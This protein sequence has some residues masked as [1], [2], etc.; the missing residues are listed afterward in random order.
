[1]GSVKRLTKNGRGAPESDEESNSD[2]SIA[3]IK[4]LVAK[5]T[6]TNALEDANGRFDT[7]K[8]RS[9]GMEG[10][11][12]SADSSPKSLEHLFNVRVANRFGLLYDP[13][14]DMNIQS[15]PSP[16]ESPSP[17]ETLQNRPPSPEGAARREPRPPPIY[18]MARLGSEHT[19]FRRKIDGIPKNYYLQ[20]TAK[21][22]IFY[23]R[24][25]A[26]YK[27]FI[28]TFKDIL[29]FY[30]FTPRNEKTHAYMV[31]GLHSDA[32]PEE[33][34]EKLSGLNIC[35]QR[36]TR[37]GKPEY[38]MF[39]VI[40]DNKTSLKDITKK[41]RF[42][43]RTRIY[44][45]PHYNK[46]LITQCQADN[47][48]QPPRNTE[49]SRNRR[50]S[51]PPLTRSRLPR[52]EFPPL[53]APRQIRAQRP[54]PSQTAW[55]QSASP[56][57]NNDDLKNLRDI[58]AT[59]SE[60]NKIVNLRWLAERVRDLHEQIKQARPPT[61]MDLKIAQWNCDG[62]RTKMGELI[63]FLS[64]RNVDLVALSETKL[65][66]SWDLQLRGY[67][68]VRKDG[69][70][71]QGGVAIAIRNTIPF[72]RIALPEPNSLEA[73]AIR[74]A[75]S[76][77]VVSLYNSPRKRL[78]INQ[79]DTLFGLA[80]KVLIAATTPGTATPTTRTETCC[81]TTPSPTNVARLNDIDTD[82]LPSDHIPL[83]Y[84]LGNGRDLQRRGNKIRVHDYA[85]E[86]WK[87]FRECLNTD[88]TMVSDLDTTRKM[89]DIVDALTTK[90]ASAADRSALYRTIHLERSD[91]LP[92]EI[93]SLIRQRNALR[94]R[95][96]AT[97]NTN[98]KKEANRIT[99]RIRWIYLAANPQS[100]QIAPDYPAAGEI[101]RDS[102]CYP[103]GNIRRNASNFEAFHLTP[104]TSPQQ[105]DLV[106]RTV[107]SFLTN[108][109]VNLSES[110]RFLTNPSMKAPGPDTIQNIVLKNL[111]KKMIV[112]LTYVVAIIKLQHY[113]QQWKTA[114]VI[115]VP[116]PNKD[117]SQSSSYRP[118][119]LLSTLSKVAE[120]II[121]GHINE[122]LERNSIIPPYQFGFRSEHNTN[123]Q[124]ARLVRDITAGFNG[125][126][127]TA[128]VL[129]DL[130]KAFDKVWHR[131]I[132]CKLIN[133]RFPGPIV[134][135]INSY[136]SN[137]SFTLRVN[138]SHSSRKLAAAGVPQGSAL[139][140]VQEYLHKWKLSANPQ[141]S[142]VTVFTRRT[143]PPLRIPRPPRFL[144]SQLPSEN[145]TRYLG[146]QLDSGL[147]FKHQIHRNINKATSLL[148]KLY[149]ILVKREAS[150][151]NKLL[152]YKA[153][154]RPVLTY[155]SPVWNH[156]AA[157]HINK[158]QVFQ[159]KCLRLALNRDR[160]TSIRALHREANIPTVSDFVRNTAE[161]FYL[162]TV[163]H[164]NPLIRQITDVRGAA[165]NHAYPYQ[166]VPLY[167]EEMPLFTLNIIQ[168]IF[169]FHNEDPIID[170][171]TYYPSLLY[172]GLERKC[173]DKIL[174][175]LMDL[176]ED[177]DLASESGTTPLL[178]ALNRPSRRI[179]HKLI[180]NGADLDVRNRFG[181]TYMHEVI[182]KGDLES[183]CM[184]LFYGA[185]VTIRNTNGKTAFEQALTCSEYQIAY[186]LM[187]FVADFNEKGDQ[188]FTTLHLAIRDCPDIVP[189]IIEK[190]ADVNVPWFQTHC[191]HLCIWWHFSSNAFRAIWPRIDF[192]IYAEFHDLNAIF[193]TFVCISKFPRKEFLK[194]MYLILDSERVQDFL[195]FASEYT[196][197][198]HNLLS[199]LERDLSLDET[200]EVIWVLLSYGVEVYFNDVC[201]LYEMYGFDECL[202]MI[203]MSGCCIYPGDQPYL[204][205]LDGY[206]CSRIMQYEL[207]EISSAIE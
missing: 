127:H 49:P 190:G 57:A 181:L 60:I 146:I 114:T 154:I 40:T 155:G 195:D 172:F 64:S 24:A 43:L 148:I 191:I 65:A 180:L 179:P 36:V 117:P 48:P 94:K 176:G 84:S 173:C 203:L 66:E 2:S 141:K 197:V 122:H 30:T 159:S 20:F 175:F 1:M 75:D 26:D 109:P 21:D 133:L 99:A 100:T 132:V 35:V 69:R 82:S 73:V 31:K 17:G 18:F 88:C 186:Y 29:P 58:S 193:N 27:K 101:E 206:K 44:I 151:R 95:F 149:P 3:S 126:Q 174:F 110:I 182:L 5:I 160:Y 116:K 83:I 81:I 19:E 7:S 113:P 45:E 23:F 90:I 74:L 38:P 50:D 188:G 102:R 106:K 192:E 201:F 170:T 134:T 115:P 187:D 147:R 15:T 111:H 171:D 143:V 34:R 162:N 104:E 59:L 56:A 52:E 140:P 68:V 14:E 93:K 72:Q 200:I 16:G 153:I 199:V 123:Q 11:A 202:E 205:P 78:T 161:K 54:T 194:C 135:L 41:V 121:L 168:E 12:A 76:T 97:R 184:L 105:E 25:M 8:T 112:Q 77:V 61:S 156:A 46:R 157:T 124:V 67:S 10:P 79:L 137:R 62:V 189:E 129:V 53:H 51:A 198:K 37:V 158:M 71:S 13:E 32:T 207:R 130:E 9:D 96:Q 178:L 128:L 169:R 185:D 144:K 47:V 92:D 183:V 145:P 164:S 4:S 163:Q 125:K 166:N 152:L 120:K 87:R 22:A 119:S 70:Y 86:N 107:S 136:L 6:K 142:S 118:I 28:A 39:L 33:V 55:S 42:L 196:S 131:G 150:T 177:I 80:L 63:D 103:R 138:D 204:N 165:T 91:R 167:A 108:N 139:G 85:R 98:Y 89:E